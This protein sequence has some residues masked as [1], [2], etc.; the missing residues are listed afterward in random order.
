MAA[1]IRILLL[2]FSIIGAES[3][4]VETSTSANSPVALISSR[5]AAEVQ[6]GSLGVF[7]KESTNGSLYEQQDHWGNQKT[8]LFYNKKFSAWAVGPDPGCLDS[9][10]LVRSCNP[11]VDCDQ[12]PPLDGWKYWDGSWKKDDTLRIAYNH[13]APACQTLELR[14]RSILAQKTLHR[15]LGRYELKPVSSRGRPTYKQIG[16]DYCLLVAEG[17]QHWVIVHFDFLNTKRAFMQSNRGTL[18]PSGETLDGWVYCNNLDQGCL[19][20]SDNSSSEEYWRVDD[21]GIEVNCLE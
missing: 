1:L 17:W 7:I 18:D 12:L 13:D 14:S 19:I 8:Y 10:L 3:W 16:S 9:A 20:D 2:G 21:A 11:I 6:G 15:F 5:G 4:L